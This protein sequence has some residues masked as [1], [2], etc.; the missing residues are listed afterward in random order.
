MP[1]CCSGFVT[2]LTFW[3]GESESMKN[4]LATEGD[5]WLRKIART[6]VVADTLLGR[7]TSAQV[8]RR[9]LYPYEVSSLRRRRTEK[10]AAPFDRGLIARPVVLAKKRT[11][12]GRHAS[13][14][15]GDPGRTFQ[16]FLFTQF[17]R[18]SPEPAAFDLSASALFR[19]TLSTG[20]QIKFRSTLPMNRQV[21]L[22]LQWKLPRGVS[23]SHIAGDHFNKG[24]LVSAFRS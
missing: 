15:I 12:P 3:R 11:R 5:G 4:I 7:W 14:W 10:F 22:C 18:I 1:E 19:K 8:R 2:G 24:S 17:R 6:V 23:R 21:A 9:G 13:P 20:I 16:P